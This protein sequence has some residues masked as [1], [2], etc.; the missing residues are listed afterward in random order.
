M[1]WQRPRTLCNLHG[2]MGQKEVGLMHQR[3]GLRAHLRMACF[4]ADTTFCTRSMKHARRHSSV[5]RELSQ[6]GEVLHSLQPRRKA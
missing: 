4:R 5:R 1:Q 2:Y 6:T 3:E